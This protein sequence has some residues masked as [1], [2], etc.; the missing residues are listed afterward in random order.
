M[1]DSTGGSKWPA[2]STN[3]ATTAEWITAQVEAICGLYPRRRL[4]DEADLLAAALWIDVLISFPKADL[5]R[6]FR[7]WARDEE[8]HP[9]PAG[10][11]RLALAQ[12]EA[13]PAPPLK[14]AP[15]PVVITADELEKRRAVSAR[16]HKQFPKLWRKWGESC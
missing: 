4:S 10:I 7:E 5:E 3:A 11:R 13:P 9:T 8:W 6:A 1:T 12:V 15:P 14:L 16:L 2:V